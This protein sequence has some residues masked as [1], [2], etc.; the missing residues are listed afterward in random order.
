VNGGNSSF[1]SLVSATGGGRGYAGNNALQTSQ[2]GG[3]GAGTGS[4]IVPG[5]SAGIAFLVGTIPAGGI[6][7]SAGMGSGSPTISIGGVGAVG[8]F[9]GGG[10]NGGS[11][12]AFAGGAGAAGLVVIEY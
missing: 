7:G 4:F 1:G 11:V 9:P 2:A 10:G 3:G 12:G 8:L 6:G 5:S